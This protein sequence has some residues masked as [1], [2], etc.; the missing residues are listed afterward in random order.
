MSARFQV[1]GLE[2]PFQSDVSRCSAYTNKPGPSIHIKSDGA[3]RTF[4]PPPPV[5]EGARPLDLSAFNILVPAGLA[6]A[7]SVPTQQAV[8]PLVPGA[9]S[10]P[11]IIA[12]PG[13]IA[14]TGLPAL[15][16][17]GGFVWARRRKAAVP[18][19]A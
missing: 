17:L 10:Q 4:S 1:L 16:T 6:A 8:S 19:A 3:A 2:Q 13:P 12:V 5:S 11:P 9:P 18:A 15:L 7:P 14:G